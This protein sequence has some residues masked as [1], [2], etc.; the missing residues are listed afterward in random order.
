MGG[1]GF[2]LQASQTLGLEGMNSFPNTLVTAVEV[3]GHLLRGL[4]LAASQENLATPEGESVGG[5][6]PLLQGRQFLL[7]KLPYNQ[8]SHASIMPYLSI[9]SNLQ[10]W[11]C[12]RHRQGCS[13]PARSNTKISSWLAFSLIMV[14]LL[15]PHA[16]R[17]LMAVPGS[18]VLAVLAELGLVNV[19]PVFGRGSG[20]QLKGFRR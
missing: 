11:I 18:T 15:T 8:C 20:G 4:A 14:A 13:C 9:H 6:Q 17:A 12:T 3:G 5:A 2:G 1:V 19:A 7:S 16:V 10:T